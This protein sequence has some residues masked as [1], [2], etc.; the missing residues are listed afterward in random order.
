M[1]GALV[2]LS[3]SGQGV[4]PT[5]PT[6]LVLFTRKRKC[7]SFIP[8][9]LDAVT[10]TLK[11]EN[12]KRNIEECAKRSLLYSCKNSIG[13][14]WGLKPH[15]IEW[16]YESMVRPIR[17]NAKVQKAASLMITSAFRSILQAAL[18]ALLCLNQLSIHLEKINVLLDV[19]GSWQNLRFFANK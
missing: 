5:N 9:M 15:I 19:T 13:K 7:A 14:R 3:S 2:I 17:A 16:V 12:W 8:P 4:N 11:L 6:E 10:L 18:G 1:Q